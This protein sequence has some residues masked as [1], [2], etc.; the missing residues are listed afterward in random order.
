MAN[1]V[2]E[3]KGKCSTC[4]ERGLAC[5]K[6]GDHI[7]CQPCL[8]AKVQD[9]VFAIDLREP[10]GAN[11]IGVHVEKAVKDLNETRMGEVGDGE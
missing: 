8:D 3:C 7:A 2:A 11:G 9:C 1:H 5:E 10:V 4:Q 6:K